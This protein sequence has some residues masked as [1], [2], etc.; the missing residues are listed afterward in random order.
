MSI[1][2]QNWKISKDMY[3]RLA[4]AKNMVMLT[5]RMS[6]NL[7]QK[8]A[9]ELCGISLSLWAQLEN[10]RALPTETE[11][12][13]V[14]TLIGKPSFKVFETLRHETIR[15]PVKNISKLAFLR[16]VKGIA[17]IDLARRA[18]VPLQVIRQL[19]RRWLTIIDIPQAD[20]VHVMT[21]ADYL[22]E[23]VVNVIGMAID[24]KEAAIGSLRALPLLS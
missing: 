13:K 8:R 15:M 3:A 20:L 10:R 2:V 23:D 1:E 7:S 16:C 22:G 6:N 12:K 5:Y 24:Q 19:E 11:A 4:L 18:E 9:A 21:L 14:A 17:Q